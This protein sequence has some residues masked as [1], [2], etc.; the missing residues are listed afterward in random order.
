MGHLPSLAS[1][2]ETEPRGWLAQS[3][4][5]DHP[6][7]AGIW[8]LKN[9]GYSEME[10]CLVESCPQGLQRG[11]KESPLPSGPYNEKVWAAGLLVC[12]DVGKGVQGAGLAALDQLECSIVLPLGTLSPTVPNGGGQTPMC[13]N[14]LK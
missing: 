6:K 9:E 3:A 8:N 5:E 14:G 4:H 2:P 13:M 10:S 12:W 7:L 1:G 11:R